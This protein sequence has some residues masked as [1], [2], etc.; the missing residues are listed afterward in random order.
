MDVIV[1]GKKTGCRDGATVSEL[2]TALDIPDDAAGVAVAVNEAVVPRLRW[3]ETR[4]SQND[5]VEVIHAV[6]GG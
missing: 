2:L 5:R 6:Q 1:N 4:L 3:N